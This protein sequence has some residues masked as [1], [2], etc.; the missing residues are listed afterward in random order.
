MGP[1][2]RELLPQNEQVVTRRPR[3]PPPS[4]PPP[5]PPPLPGRLLSAMKQ[6]SPSLRG[7]RERECQTPVTAAR[8]AGA[9][10]PS[11]PR[12]AGRE[13]ISARCDSAAPV[14]SNADPRG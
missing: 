2:S 5:A 13:V 9:P 3:K 10:W 1:T 14:V 7:E 6:N 8:P 4:P 12:A 11:G